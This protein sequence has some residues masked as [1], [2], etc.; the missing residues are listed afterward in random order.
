MS[1]KSHDGTAI[2]C[3][4]IWKFLWHI[5][6]LDAMFLVFWVCLMVIAFCSPSFLTWRALYAVGIIRRGH[7]TW[8][9]SFGRNYLTPFPIHPPRR[10]AASTRRAAALILRLAVFSSALIGR[11]RWQG[12]GRT[13]TTLAGPYF[14]VA[15]L[16]ASSRLPALQ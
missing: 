10:N 15:L 16:V 7:D 5:D 2:T 1:C 9:P 11:G 14:S 13:L 8:H 6:A 4:P 3:I 12:D